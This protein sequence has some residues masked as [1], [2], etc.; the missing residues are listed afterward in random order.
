MVTLNR[1]SVADLDDS[2]QQLPE[3]AEAATPRPA[4]HRKKVVPKTDSRDVFL[5]REENLFFSLML[6]IG[7]YLA[8]LIPA[9]LPADKVAAIRDDYQQ[10]KDMAVLNRSASLLAGP[11][12]PRWCL[13]HLKHLSCPVGLQDIPVFVQQERR[14]PWSLSPPLGFQ[15]IEQHLAV[16]LATLPQPGLPPSLKREGS[17]TRCVVVGSGGILHGSHLGSHIDQYDIIIR[18]NN[19]P[20][21]GFERDVGSR[22]T[23]RLTYPEG[24]PH[25]SNEYRKTSIFAVV[26]FKS[27]D[28]DWLT[29][30]ITK[31]PLSF[32]SKMWFWKEVVDHIPLTPESFKIVHPEIIHKMGQVIEK[33][34]LNQRNNILPTIG[35]TGVVMALQMCD[36][37]SLAGF[38][39][40]MQHPEARLHYYEAI[41]MDTMKSQV[42]HDITAE[43]L[44]LKDL[45]A[46]GVVTDLTGGV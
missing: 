45:V 25:S 14:E 13:N 39:Y 24:A 22:T 18:L 31:Q 7:C 3:A 38:G 32:W 12:L 21:H 2:S 23:I 16:A 6:L 30:V 17:C 40:D 4:F 37:V 9:Y 1:L 26:V 42:V 11:C 27:L 15:G 10:P 44:F 20:V 46:A 41:R 8:I 29:S 34:E 33:Y 36:Q 19:A 28:L 35:A 43:K 5:N